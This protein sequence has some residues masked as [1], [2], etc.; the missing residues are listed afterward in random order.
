[1]GSVKYSKEMLEEVVR[2]SLAVSEVLRFLD[3]KQTG[4]NYSY[5]S[6]LIKK[7]EIDTKH[8]LGRKLYMA[9]NPPVN[10]H[11]KETFLRT[12]KENTK[13]DGSKTKKFLIK[14]CMKEHKCEICKNTE[15]F[16]KK[17]PLEVDHINGD[18]FD[19]RLENIRLVCPNCHALTETYCRTKTSVHRQTV[20][21]V[22]L[23][24]TSKDNNLDES[25]NL[26]GRICDNCGKQLSKATKGVFCKT[27][28]KQKT[29]IEWPDIILLNK[30]LEEKTLTAI[31]L[32]LGVSANAIKKHLRNSS[33]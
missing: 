20:K 27:C 9:T 25:S 31:A 16:G 14:F 26:S 23:G 29:K 18:H 15:W 1:M 2:K 4:G 22:G 30:M 28:Y 7:Y 21:S 17:I 8:F 12:L 33:K 11:T 10:K 3:L 6:S 24:P 5:I 13:L 32:S 19:N